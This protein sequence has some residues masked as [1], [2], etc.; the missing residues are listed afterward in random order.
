MTM[1]HEATPCWKV[2]WHAVHFGLRWGAQFSFCFGRR[3]MS[4]DFGLAD[5]FINFGDL[6]SWVYGA[7]ELFG[8]HC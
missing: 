4:G 5:V 2:S 8:A 7:F 3:S 1:N 6:G